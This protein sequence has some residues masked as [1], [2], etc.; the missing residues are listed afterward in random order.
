LIQAQSDEQ[1]S[2]IGSIL[3]AAIEK[4]GLAILQL[5]MIVIPLMIVIQILKDLQWLKKFSIG[6]SPVTRSL[7]MNEN[8]STTMAAG[9]LF[10]L[11]FG[12]GVVIQAVEEDGVS[13]KDLT[14]AFIFLLSCHAVVED[15]LI[16]IPL[17]IPVW[18]LFLIRLGVAITL[19]LV[20]GF[21]WK[22]SG[23]ISRKEAEQTYE[24]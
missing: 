12:A 24:K 2:G 9:L 21:F 14:L 8:T 6:M 22:K 11:A 1:I 16:F 23:I 20:V 10:G 5:A 13:K 15:T 17:G 7:G 3:L 19:T 4:A 18:P